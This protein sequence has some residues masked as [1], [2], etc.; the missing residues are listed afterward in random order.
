MDKRYFRM[1]ELYGFHWFD[2]EDLLEDELL[3]YG[4]VL[5]NDKNQM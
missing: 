3:D 2:I 4:S 1:L 5:S